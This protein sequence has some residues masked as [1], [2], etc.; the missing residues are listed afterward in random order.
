MVGHSCA[1][2]KR[3]KNPAAAGFGRLKLRTTTL[4]VGDEPGASVA[5]ARAGLELGLG[6]NHLRTVM[7][8]GSCVQEAATKGGPTPWE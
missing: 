1:Q 4:D 5:P 8:Q 2:R 7:E 6:F 3:V